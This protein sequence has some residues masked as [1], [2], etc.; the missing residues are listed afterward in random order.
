MAGRKFG[1]ALNLAKQE[2]QNARVQNLSS[3]PTSP[4][5]GQAYYDTTI[6]KFGIFNGTTWTYMGS[7]EATGDVSSNTSSS[8]ND[9]LVVASGTSGKVIKFF[10]GSGIVRL[11]NGVVSTGVVQITEGGTGATTASEARDNLGLTIGEDV[12]APNGDGSELTGL[13]ITQINDLQ[14]QLDL[15]AST[16]YVNLRF[17]SVAKGIAWKKPAYVATTE[18]ITLT[19]TP[20]LTIDGVSGLDQAGDT[21]ILVKDQT[22]ASENGIYQYDNGEWVRASDA[23]DVDS[24]RGMAVLVEKGTV[25]ADTVWTLATDDITELDVT[26]LEFVQINGGEVPAASTTTQGKVQLATQSEA[27]AKT[28]TDK[29]VTPASLARFTQQRQYLIGDGTTMSIAITHNLN[30]E[31]PEVS[32]WEVATRAQVDVDV[33]STNA[34]VITLRFDYVAPT[35]DQYRVSV[36]G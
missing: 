22:D 35:Q 4:V 34:N 23:N 30:N 9:Q 21:R 12:L 15:K 31:W 36:T 24:I 2:L 20:T 27:E 28:N 26:P 8:T 3:A 17:N 25:N 6:G 16:D 11:T 10:T 18:N 5:T 19:G 13:Q 29:A 33:V 1:S 32:V 7:S 14:N